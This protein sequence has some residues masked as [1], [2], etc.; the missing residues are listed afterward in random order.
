MKFLFILLI[1][2]SI[3]TDKKPKTIPPD[4]KGIVKTDFFE[5]DE[6]LRIWR[7]P[8]GGAVFEELIEIT[9]SNGIYNGTKYTYIIEP[10]RKDKKF[11]EFR[12]T[13]ILDLKK[14]SPSRFMNSRLLHKDVEPTANE[15][16]NW[17]A[18]SYRVEYR[19]GNQAHFFDF[20]F[21]ETSN[22]NLSK[23]KLMDFVIS[24]E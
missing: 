10:Y 3:V 4:L 18:D 14:E 24:L 23:L 21:K 8:E 22:T 7:F 1:F 16:D 12:E 9:N 20:M 5:P 15:R 17:H 19:K 2:F 6:I 11:N 13:K